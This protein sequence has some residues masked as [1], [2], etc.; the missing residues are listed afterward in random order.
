MNNALFPTFG[1]P[2][3]ATVAGRSIA[4]SSIWAGC[5]AWEI[6]GA[7]R[8]SHRVL[9]LVA[10]LAAIL[11]F[12]SV[13]V[14]SL[15]SGADV[16][17]D[18]SYI[19]RTPVLID[20]LRTGKHS[21]TVTKTG[22]KVEEIDSEIAPGATTPAW[23]Q[24]TALKPPPATGSLVLDGV[25]S[26]ARVSIDGQSAR[27]VQARYEIPAGQHHLTVR[28]PAAKFERDVTIYPDQT[29]H[30]LLLAPAQSH[31]AIV[32]PISDYMPAN[33]AKI[34]GDR[35]VVRWNAHSVKGRLGDAKFIVDGR[36]VVYDAP[37]GMVGGKL[38]LPLELLLT[39]TGSKK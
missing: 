11:P 23:V 16:W 13:Y 9:H 10:F 15:P 7:A 33:A 36:E 12:G 26:G 38:Y 30:V 4:R 2:T 29:T 22:W 1:R 14:S 39:M 37:A 20:G 32:A 34:Q 24:L 25:E 18:G 5:T 27:S 6:P 3:I 21:L 28:E 35:L 8:Y 31:S 17:I 19:G